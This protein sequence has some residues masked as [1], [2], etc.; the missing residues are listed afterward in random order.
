MLRE[1]KAHF[2][3]KKEFPSHLVL[4]CEKDSIPTTHSPQCQKVYDE[5][6]AFH[7]QPMVHLADY[8][9]L[10]LKEAFG[11]NHFHTLVG[12]EETFIRYVVTLKRYIKH[13]RQYGYEVEADSLLTYLKEKKWL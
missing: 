12:Y 11:I 4:T 10:Q 2:V 13:L 5:V 3:T 6:L 7:T 8:T 1:H 9:N